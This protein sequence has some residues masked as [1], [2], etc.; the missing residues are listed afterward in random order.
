VEAGR[1]VRNLIATTRAASGRARFRPADGAGRR[2]KIIAF[3]DQGGRPR[4]SITAGSYTA[5]PRL[6][7]GRPRH[8]RIRRRG[9]RLVVSWRAPRRGFRHA[10]Y[11][12]LGDGRRL[13]RIASARRRSVTVSGVARG[14]GAVATIAGLSHANGRGPSKRVAIAAQPARPGVGRWRVGKAFG[15]VKKGRFSVTR[16]GGAVSALRVTPGPLA[17]RACGKRE[18]RMAGR[19]RLTRSS[20]RAGLALWILGRR[21]RRTQDGAAPVRVRLSQAKKR[22]RATLELRFAGPRHALGELRLS[23][24]RLFFEARRG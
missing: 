5:P 19:R 17:A 18:L 11:V 4:A 13:V 21:A 22:R 23:G 9:S 7:P 20:T 24:C 16:G 8:A 12:R 3:V 2:R 6:R 1:D 15:Y 14:N 10:V